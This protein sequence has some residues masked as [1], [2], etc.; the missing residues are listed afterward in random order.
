MKSK[1]EILTASPST[2]AVWLMQGEMTPTDFK[3]YMDHLL[4]REFSLGEMHG[5]KVGRD[6]S[7]FYG[8]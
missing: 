6:S 4:V 7:N 5:I 1:H 8:G 3:L 2:I